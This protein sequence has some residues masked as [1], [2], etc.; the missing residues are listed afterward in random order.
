MFPLQPRSYSDGSYHQTNLKCQI[1]SEQH[2]TEVSK[3]PLKRTIESQLN[4]ETLPGY[5]KISTGID[6]ATVK[7]CSGIL[8]SLSSYT[9]NKAHVLKSS[10][11]LHLICSPQTIFQIYVHS[12]S[13]SLFPLLS[14]LY[15]I[16]FSP[17]LSAS[18]YYSQKIQ[19]AT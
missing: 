7:K 16:F 3:N 15:S 6:Q 11:H 13:S 8:S 18:S 10:F 5:H 12:L 19:P 4:R 14:S 9:C 1:I 17:Q 2:S